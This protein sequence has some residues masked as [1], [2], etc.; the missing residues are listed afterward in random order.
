MQTFVN[1]ET[2]WAKALAPDEDGSKQTLEELQ[3]KFI[4][5]HAVRILLSSCA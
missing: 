3:K 1:M 5:L 4:L 2:E